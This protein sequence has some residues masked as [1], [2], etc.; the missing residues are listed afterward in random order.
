MRIYVLVTR[1]RPL[2]VHLYREGIARFSSERYD[3]RSL[4]N[5]FS[6]LTNTSINKLAS[7]RASLLSGAGFSGQ[8]IKWTF[9]QMRAYFRVSLA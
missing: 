7:N 1:M 2:T 8:G 9:G 4:G 3:T 5:L 6:H